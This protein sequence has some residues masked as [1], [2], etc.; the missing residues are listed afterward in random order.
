[1]VKV[2][3]VKG[4]IR[5]RTLYKVSSPGMK[6]TFHQTKSKAKEVAEDLR[7]KKRRSK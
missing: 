6:S 5:G 7:M 1:M 2:T 3:E 4:I